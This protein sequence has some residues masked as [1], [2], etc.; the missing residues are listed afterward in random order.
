LAGFPAPSGELVGDGV[1]KDFG[2]LVLADGYGDEG[3]AA[4]GAVFAGVGTLRRE[5]VRDQLPGCGFIGA[6]APPAA[7]GCGGECPNGRDEVAAGCAFGVDAVPPPPPTLQRRHR[8]AVMPR[9]LAIQRVGD[10]A[11][12]LVIDVEGVDARAVS[13]SASPAG[14]TR[15]RR[16][17]RRRIPAAAFGLKQNLDRCS[18]VSSTS[19]KEHALP[20]LGDAEILSV[21]YPLGPPITPLCEIPPHDG[22]V[23]SA[24]DGV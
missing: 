17:A 19:D 20:P 15:P 22:D 23:S 18:P 13:A 14:S 16:A 11:Y 2:A 24:V 4:A 12:G 7:W 10:V 21:Q 1:F 5:R 9:G 8:L 3:C 6:D